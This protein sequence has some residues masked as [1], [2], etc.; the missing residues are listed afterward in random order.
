MRTY[1][2]REIWQVAR[3]HN[4]LI[5]DDGKGPNERLP[6]LV[7]LFTVARQILPCPRLK[8][9]PD[10][11]SQKQGMDGDLANHRK[12]DRYVECSPGLRE[13][14][15]PIVPPEH[16]HSCNECQQFSPFNPHILALKHQRSWKVVNL[17]HGSN[18]NVEAREN[19]D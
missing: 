14:A 5:L 15:C 4:L 16:E 3:A 17:A 12:A 11:H 8:E 2:R 6:D 18:R 1:R 9:E 13:P 19:Q 7:S 10:N